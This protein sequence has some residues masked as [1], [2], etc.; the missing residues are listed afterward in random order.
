MPQSSRP[1]SDSEE[2]ET[3]AE[4]LLYRSPNPETR[5]RLE[6]FRI[7]FEAI[8]GPT[9]LTRRYT[10]TWPVAHQRWLIKHD[11]KRYFDGLPPFGKA[12]LRAKMEIAASEG[13][14]DDMPDGLLRIF[15]EKQMILEHERDRP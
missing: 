12:Y 9:D 6:K 15:I 8:H 4:I 11:F 14:L 10:S 5:R 2:P 7:D 3:L 13:K 1:Q